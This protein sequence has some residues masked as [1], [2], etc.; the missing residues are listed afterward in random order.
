[1]ENLEGLNWEDFSPTPDDDRELQKIRKS[2][3]K[4]NWFVI[5]TSIL[6]VAVLAVG[7]F[8]VGIPALESQYWD[9][10]VRTYSGTTTDLE[11]AAV[12]FAE[13]FC[14]NQRV[15]SVWTTKTGF[16]SYDLTVQFYAKADEYNSSFQYATLEKGELNF[17]SGFWSN[18]DT[19]FLADVPEPG[20]RRELMHQL[21]ELPN[22]YTRIRAAVTFM[23][24]M[25][26]SDFEQ[27]YANLLTS[28][29]FANV[30][31][32]WAGIRVEDEDGHLLYPYSGVNDSVMHT[33]YAINRVYPDFVH[34]GGE[35]ESHYKSLLQYSLD[36][37]KAGTG[38]TSDFVS[39]DYYEKAL[40]YVA[41]NG[42]S[43]YGCYITCKPGE[44]YKL[45]NTGI[46]SK[47]IVT[48]C[49]MDV[50]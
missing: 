12:A 29:Y 4:R 18:S 30:R 23:E 38:I 6:L 37:Q 40:A 46:F 42:V 13:L 8:Y 17:P 34:R 35:L 7:V 3:R 10:T 19:V 32:E 15:A 22:S 44:L 25:S 24:D 14:P 36:Q 33:D 41:E 2:I 21:E 28:P 48:N 50:G 1:M 47:V 26:G 20:S 49:W 16:A 27:W 43:C 31:I 45:I 5:L 11:Y 39:E 9:P